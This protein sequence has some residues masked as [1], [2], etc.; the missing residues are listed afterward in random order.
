MGAGN[1]TDDLKDFNHVLAVQATS[2]Q[3]NAYNS[4][5]KSGETASQKLQ[6]FV[7]QLQK[8]PNAV[9]LSQGGH[10]LDQDIEKA[11]TETKQF[12]EAFSKTQQSGLR[13]I[14]LRVT[15][16]DSEVA[17]QASRL[18][19]QTVEANPG[20]AQISS[21]AKSLE[22]AL[23]NFREQQ[24]NLGKEM[25]ISEDISFNL[26]PTSRAITVEN[27]PISVIVS[28]VITKSAS[29]GDQSV[30][31]LQLTTDLS[32]LQ[33][34]ITEILR[35]RI[36]RQP[37]CGERHSVRR[38]TLTASSAA[39]IV[40]TQL[41]FE[42]WGCFGLPGAESSSELAEGDGTL[43]VKLRP[44][45]AQNSTLQLVSEVSRID[46]DGWA[47]ELLRSQELGAKL[48]DEITEPI[49]TALQTATDLKATL[50]ELAQGATTINKTE[51]YEAGGLHLVLEGVIRISDQQLKALGDRS[52]DHLSA[53]GPSQ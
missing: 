19:Q 28:G 12:I 6:A 50:P 24:F 9:E 20:V 29:E 10:S 27:D 13:E 43:T 53:Q 35:S 52:K 36:Y 5:V 42:R 15:K 41:H 47:G 33:Q 51:F 46:G 8:N 14:A 18:D 4:M 37:R 25:G 30:F 31:K 7:E 26:S 34:N 38:A 48:R 21:C 22:Q 49:Q 39:S 16:A 1:D 45:L 32:D 3:V 23:A 11:R 40:V 17:Q 44:R 2:E